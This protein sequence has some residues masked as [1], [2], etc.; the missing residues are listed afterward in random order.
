VGAGVR[1]GDA[2]KGGAGVGVEVGGAFA[3]EIGRPEEAV[4]TGG[5]FRGECCKVIVGV[6]GHEGVAEVAEAE[7][8]AV[9]DSHDVPDAGC[10]VTEGVD[11]A[12]GV[13]RRC[14]GGGEND[15]GGPNGGGDRAWGE[16]AHADG[17]GALVACA[18]GYWQAFGK[19]GC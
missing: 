9:G 11:A 15:T 7:A 17:S 14:G 4:A 10:G 19:A 2:D 5:D 3:E 16:D 1:S 8:R 13:E 18:G 6:Q 12:P